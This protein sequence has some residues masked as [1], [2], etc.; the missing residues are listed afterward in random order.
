[1][2]Y[3]WFFLRYFSNFRSYSRCWA[4]SC[5]MIMALILRKLRQKHAKMHTVRK[6]WTATPCKAS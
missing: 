2:D 3:F 4:R 1:M 6:V 5:M